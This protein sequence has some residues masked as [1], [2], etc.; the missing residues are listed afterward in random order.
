MQSKSVAIEE[1]IPVIREAVENGSGINMTPRGQSMLPFISGRNSVFL[2]KPPVRLKKYD[3]ALYYR[4]K[5]GIYVMHRM[6][7]IKNGGYVFCGDN[8]AWKETG[9]EDP[10]IIALVTSVKEENKEKM[11]GFSY[12]LYCRTLFLRRFI[13]KIKWKLRTVLKRD[14]K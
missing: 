14:T 6:I 12:A 5:T 3:V 10:D 4:R 9:V 11:R 2:E 13:K 8:Q 7:K 1:L